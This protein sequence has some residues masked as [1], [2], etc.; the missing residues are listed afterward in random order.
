MKKL[1]LSFTFILSIILLSILPVKSSITFVE[2]TPKTFSTPRVL[3]SNFYDDGTIVVRIVRVNPNHKAP[4]KICV[5][6]FLSLRI[7][8]PDKTIKKL[9]LSAV[10]LN[11]QPFNF[12]LFP[13]ANPIR[14][15]P[16]KKN[17][18]LITYA[19]AEDV[20]SP[21]TYNDWGMIIGLDG[22]FKSKIWLGTSYVNTTT[23]EWL[24]AQDS[25]TLNI[26]RDNGFLRTAPVTG[27][28]SMTLK[29]FKVNETGGIQLLAETSMNFTATPIE[30][31]AT[32]DGGYAIIYPDYTPS[33]I[34]FAPYISIHGFFLQNGNPEPQGPFVLYQ[35]PNP[36]SKI[37]LLD[38]DFTKVGFGQ[39]CILVLNIAP[40]IDRNT[41][42]KIDFLS[43]G[44][45]YNITNFQN[46]ADL[47]DFTVES[48]QYGGYLLY[49]R[50]PFPND[51]TK[52]N[53][54]GYILDD[55]GN[56]YDWNIS[57]P[58]T[59]NFNGDVLVLPN[60]TIAI[61]QPE[62]QQTWGLLT[63]DLYKI[64]GAQ[65]HGYGNLHIF[66]TT[67]NIGEIINP[68]KIEFLTIQFYDKV[69]LSP[70][71][72][73]TILQ[74]GGIIRQITSVSHNNGDFV[75]N[76]DD[77][78]IQIKVINSTFN[79]PNT[80]YYIIMDDG[81]VK[82]KDLQ[83]PIIGIQD[84]SWKFMTIKE[85]VTQNSG[86][87]NYYESQVNATAINGKVLLNVD[88]TDYFKGIKDDKI[89]V[90]EFFNNL[91]RELAEAI[92]VDS[93]RIYT[94]YKHEID[95]STSPEQYILSINI[96][97]AKN[98]TERSVDS[99]SDNLNT[100]I[101]NK[102]IT[103]IGT[104]K[105]TNYL[106]ERYG[107]VPI[108]RWITEHLGSLLGTIA[109][110]IILL[111][112]AYW[113]NSIAIFSC[114]NAVEKFVTTILFT[115]K[116]ADSV[117]KIFP[118]SLFFV[119]FPFIVNLGF[120]FKV[121][122][123]E[124][125]R[126][127]LR[128]LLKTVKRLKDDLVKDTVEEGNQSTVVINNFTVVQVNDPIIEVV[129]NNTVNDG[130]VED[131]SKK[132][133]KVVKREEKVKK[134]TKVLRE[135]R[136]ELKKINEE[137]TEVSEFSKGLKNVNESIKK[138]KDSNPNDVNGIMKKSNTVKD[139]V[140]KLRG[141]NNLIERLMQV[142]DFTEE[143]IE[144]CRNLTVLG[145]LSEE[146]KK[147]KELEEVINSR[148]ES[149]EAREGGTKFTEGIGGGSIN[150]LDH[151]EKHAKRFKEV[152][153][154]KSRLNKAVK[155]MNE[156]K[157]ELTTSENELEKD[158]TTI[159]PELTTSRNELTKS[160]EELISELEK[161]ESFKK[162][163]E[164]LEKLESYKEESEEESNEEKNEED[165]R[166]DSIWEGVKKRFSRLISFQEKIEKEAKKAIEK[167][168]PPKKYRKFS[169]WLR[170]Y[171]DSQTIVIIFTILAGVDISHLELLGSKLRIKIPSIKY[172]DLN[173]RNIDV[174]FNAKLSHAAKHSLFLGD[175][176]N[177]FIEDIST[178]FIQCFYLGQVVS[179]GYTPIYTITKSIIHL[180][181]NLFHIYTYKRNP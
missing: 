1:K 172:F 43:T 8:Y 133:D 110:N 3:N 165:D 100:L 144:I 37:I 31:V 86:F 109:L 135:T 67:P 132:D 145:K 14:F 105:Y 139:I 79:Q 118:A 40:V 95:T 174:N 164:K 91:T 158:P 72:N 150:E 103:V 137:L 68:S 28:N 113:C 44:T 59:T 20:N 90:K 58:T 74:D 181:N 156:L 13:T 92:P 89:K 151:I 71:H 32:M 122:I 131:G 77:Y 5:E 101:K 9:D 15:Y 96:R 38:C 128:K 53:L 23:N 57:Y 46:P 134:L 29:Q 93:E 81:F 147:I 114:G 130:R 60:N 163:L 2:E 170:D 62:F 99:I 155:L 76:I 34:P 83:E 55:H 154:L 42:I 142:E 19:E 73:I 85:D 106:D 159:D 48:L 63:T 161:L 49:S 36:V 126:H 129:N 175:V 66:N 45:V 87:S 124:L 4:P 75:K 121:V 82:S 54:Y 173:T 111:S 18:L 162:E 149:I 115:S 94:N 171:K 152:E 125:M 69:N 84:N 176:T 80:M 33:T 30:T 35:T 70:N 104:G 168:Q 61:P 116:D 24:P 22:S 138:N 120:A 21:Y 97:K 143:I 127:D 50:A 119:T 177:I 146:L 10:T 148:K 12:C 136:K 180:L 47:I 78:T 140:E 141:I 39:T 26:H 52:L 98:K 123:D 157:E 102:L 17:F 179:F 41:F 167:D 16:V 112:L 25:V 65:D 107:Y 108:P 7:I 88:G 153:N 166:R 64:K 178:I 27:T 56:R 11:I 117:E 6:E 51:M 160:K 169:K